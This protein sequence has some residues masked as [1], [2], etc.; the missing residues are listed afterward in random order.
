MRNSA[1]NLLWFIAGTGIGVGT[2]YLF[3]TK[4]GKKF[5]RQMARTMNEGC[6]QIGE[7]RRELFERGKEILDEGKEFVEQTG[8]RVGASLHV[9][10]K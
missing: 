9:A 10:A 7:A 5:R 1:G 8:K 2:M 3:G 4:E 6:E